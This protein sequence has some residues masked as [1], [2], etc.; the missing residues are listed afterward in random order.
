MRPDRPRVP[1]ERAVVLAQQRLQLA[2]VLAARVTVGAV[3]AAPVPGQPLTGVG[4]DVL[5]VTQVEQLA[6]ER[7]LGLRIRSRAADLALENDHDGHSATVARR[8][9]ADH[10]KRRCADWQGARG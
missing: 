4:V 10:M 9:A 5:A 3:D 2:S 6:L 8:G 1:A 7:Y